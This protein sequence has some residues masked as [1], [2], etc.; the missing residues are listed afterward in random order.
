VTQ[1]SDRYVIPV[2]ADSAGSVRG[3]VHD[4]SGSGATLFVEP[5]EVLDANNE[6]QRRRDAESREIRRILEELTGRIAAD[7]A[8]IE[9]SLDAVEAVDAVQARALWGREFAA[10]AP[11]TGERLV[12]RGARHPLLEAQLRSQERSSV[13]LDL[14]LGSAHV[15]VLTGPNAGG[16]TVALKTIGLLALLHQA[17]VPVPAAPDSELPVYTRI[18]AD[19]GDEQSIEAAESTFSSH[20]RHVLELVRV[21][22]SRSLA[23][24]D[25]FMAGTDP[26]EGAALAQVVLRRLAQRG[27]TTFVTT[28]LAALKLFATAS[29]GS[30]TPAWRSTAISAHRSTAATR[31]TGKQQRADHCGASRARPG[32]ARGSAGGARRGSGTA[33]RRRSRRSKPNAPGSA[34]LARRPRPPNTKHGACAR[35]M[36]RCTPR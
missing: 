8:A 29:R 26:D 32:A 6:L 23:L 27:C 35:S 33:R 19:I 17:G 16:K 22:G 12:L 31:R 25:E 3:I 20:L 9:A 13:P 18:H 24:L 2:R 5:L 28:H 11:R 1:R 21:A 36:R 4:R 34:R 30:S 10:A 15:L 14:E 7:A